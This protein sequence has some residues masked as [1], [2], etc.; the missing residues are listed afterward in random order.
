MTPF[1]QRMQEIRDAPTGGKIAAFFDYD[2]T[3]IE[4]FSVVALAKDRVRR[5]DVS[6]S[7]LAST[8]LIGLRGVESEQDYAA[9]LDAVRPSFARKT[10]AEML[11]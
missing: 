1:A 5:G 8:V 11:A 4:G 10:Y 2:G 9:V 3:L 7:E 6:L